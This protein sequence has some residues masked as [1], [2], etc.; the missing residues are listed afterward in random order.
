MSLSL[1]GFRVRIKIEG[2][3]SKPSPVDHLSRRSGSLSSV[4]P[5]LQ[6]SFFSLQFLVFFFSIYFLKMEVLLFF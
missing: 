2:L 5:I 6:I 3:I 1:F 4:S